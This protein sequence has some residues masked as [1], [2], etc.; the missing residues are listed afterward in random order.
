MNIGEDKELKRL[1]KEFTGHSVQEREHKL[2]LRMFAF[3]MSILAVFGSVI[4]LLVKEWM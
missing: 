2:V 1:I 4:F 3:I